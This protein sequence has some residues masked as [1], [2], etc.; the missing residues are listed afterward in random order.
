MQSAWSETE[1]E[2][3]RCSAANPA[4]ADLASRVYTS[5]LIGSDPDL[6]LHGGGNTS[7]KLHRVLNGDREEAILHVK[8]S[9][10][11]L[12]TIEAAGLPA[13]KLK[14]L[15]EARHGRKLGDLEMVETLRRHLLDPAAPNPSIET[16]LHAFL[17]AKFVDHS[18]ATAILVLA[19]QPDSADIAVR[20][21][22]GRLA[23]VP[24]VMPG[25]DL[26]IA[27]A[28]AFDSNPDCEGLWLVNHGIFTWGD[29][30]RQS[31]ERMIEFVSIAEHHLRSRGVHLGGTRALDQPGR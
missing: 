2:R 13:L 24:Y 12:G 19:D 11:D 30:A 1:E 3:W 5:R 27:G 4:E 10:W 20:L 16:L 14:P 25:Y 28:E 26:S 6:V 15:L 17:P 22:G 9:G 8:G 7:V 18:H 31:Y 23:I 29:T 21:F